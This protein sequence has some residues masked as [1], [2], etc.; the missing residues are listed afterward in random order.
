MRKKLSYSIL[1]HSKRPPYESHR[2]GYWPM[3]LPHLPSQS[4]TRPIWLQAQVRARYLEAVLWVPVGQGFASVGRCI[5]GTS[6]KQLVGIRDSIHQVYVAYNIPHVLHALR[7][8]W[9]FATT[10]E[11][12][13]SQ[14]EAIYSCHFPIFRRSEPK[15]GKSN[16]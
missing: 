7:S 15:K 10:F 9:P 5:C 3:H 14:S 12:L 11:V 1:D 2:R 16:M 8:R 13:T 4:Q 6:V